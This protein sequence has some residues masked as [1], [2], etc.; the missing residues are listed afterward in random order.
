MW[1]IFK[2]SDFFFVTKIFCL[3]P[4]S[5]R[6]FL[7]IHLYTPT[8]RETLSK[9][10][11]P[12]WCSSLSVEVAINEVASVVSRSVV[13][14]WQKVLDKRIGGFI[15]LWMPRNVQAVSSGFAQLLM[16]LLLDSGPGGYFH[17]HVSLYVCAPESPR[18]MSPRL[19]SSRA[20]ARHRNHH[21]PLTINH[22]GRC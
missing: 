17:P 3:Y 8:T 14:R 11:E 7:S 15:R 10:N 5:S 19:T 13:V 4:L 16:V 9:V 20:R 18:L 22:F 6:C 1:D 21:S 12:S 2:P